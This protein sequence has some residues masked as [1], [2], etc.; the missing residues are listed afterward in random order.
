MNTTQPSP[1]PAFAQTVI[2]Y[3]DPS[4]AR[5]GWAMLDLVEPEN[6]TIILDPHDVTVAKTNPPSW[7]FHTNVALGRWS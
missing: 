4:E 2:N 7:R 6:T 1:Y 5:D 3:H